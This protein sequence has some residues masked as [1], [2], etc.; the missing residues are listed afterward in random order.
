MTLKAFDVYVVW[1]TAP[2]R[3]GI[4][5]PNTSFSAIA[6]FVAPHM[7]KQDAGDMALRELRSNGIAWARVTRVERAHATEVQSEAL[8]A[9]MMLHMHGVEP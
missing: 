7:T 3:A 5:D 6:T 2:A 1:G 9:I 4:A 8:L